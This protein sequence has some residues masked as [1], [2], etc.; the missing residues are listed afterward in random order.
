MKRLVS[1]LVA[2][3]VAFS[4]VL[5]V[6]AEK[7]D[8][9]D[10]TPFGISSIKGG[11]LQK[12][13]VQDGA[14]CEDEYSAPHISDGKSGLEITFSD[15]KVSAENAEKLKLKQ[16]TFINLDR[17]YIYCA[18]RL[19]VD[20][21]TVEGIYKKN[22]GQV[23]PVSFF[24]GLSPGEH[25]ANRC[26][27]WNNTY[28]FSAETKTCVGV[29][30]ERI[31]RS[32]EEETVFS[33]RISNIT[34]L[35][36]ENGYTAPDGVKWTADHYG[37]NVGF[38]MKKE[39]GLT[40]ITAEIIIPIGDA[41]LAVPKSERSDVAEKLQRQ[42][43]MIC[44]SFLS[45]IGLFSD[46]TQAVLGVPTEKAY[47]FSEEQSIKGYIKKNYKTPVSGVFLPKFLPIPLHFFREDAS[48]SNPGSCVLQPEDF[49]GTEFSNPD[50]DV[51]TST[52]T[53]ST[54]HKTSASGCEESL[55]QESGILFG[56]KD[57]L[58]EDESIFD[59]LPD[60]DEFL[61]EDTEIVYLSQSEK[62][63]SE[64][65]GSLWGSVLTFLAG[66]FLFASMIVFV[67]F[68]REEKGGEKEEGKKEKKVK[69]AKK[70]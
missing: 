17:D 61:P 57:Q 47:P 30:G 22:L 19:L 40:H 5:P 15:G 58:E 35:Y 29:S 13:P 39:N 21:E 37:E 28:Y 69:K 70:G 42:T 38:S 9:T 4:I 7:I 36:G 56:E 10:L 6:F 41:L 11:A 60:E 43:D 27:F 2:V 64:K 53:V 52:I 12:K 51:L 31:A 34:D 33:L 25:P 23:Y 66:V 54:S 59:S 68:V 16:E 65:K 63:S 1:F 32:V 45:Q 3:F 50:N 24:I 18:I 8:L 44:G 55:K 49:E 20:T 46:G 67:F 62:A 26:S 14:I 48:H